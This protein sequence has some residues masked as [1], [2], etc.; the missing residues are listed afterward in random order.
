M[1]DNAQLSKIKREVGGRPAA[2]S[3][4]VKGI[5]APGRLLGSMSERAVYCWGCEAPRAKE[6]AQ[7]GTSQSVIRSLGVRV[8]SGCPACACGHTGI[9]IQEPVDSRDSEADDEGVG[10]CQQT[11]GSG[12][13]RPATRTAKPASR[14]AAR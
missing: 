10:S 9:A 13:H 14:R 2:V 6:D 8:F 12:Q 7:R 11:V 4:A 5:G 3:A 1:V